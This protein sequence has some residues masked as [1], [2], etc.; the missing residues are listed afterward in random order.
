MLSP[1]LQERVIQEQRLPSPSSTDK[2]PASLGSPSPVLSPPSEQPAASEE[3]PSKEAAK[4]AQQAGP[5]AP[6]GTAEKE[7]SRAGG[8]PQQAGAAGSPGVSL[9]SE[10]LRLVD[11]QI[12][13]QSQS[14]LLS[15]TPSAQPAEDAGAGAGPSAAQAEKEAKYAGLQEIFDGDL[16][17]IRELGSGTFGTVHYGKWRG[18]DVAIKRLKA[19]VFSGGEDEDKTVSTAPPQSHTT[20]QSVQARAWLLSG[21]V[22]GLSSCGACWHLRLSR[23]VSNFVRILTSFDYQRGFLRGPNLVWRKPTPKASGCLPG[24]F[25]AASLIS[26]ELLSLVVFLGSDNAFW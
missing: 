13:F 14:Q 23:R 26:T 5:S 10:Q 19:S 2:L 9:H 4:A 20:R 6:Q 15:E 18:T 17:E 21:R 16:E 24:P 12:R 25:C 22:A 8:G 7:G 1:S 11:D 3:Q